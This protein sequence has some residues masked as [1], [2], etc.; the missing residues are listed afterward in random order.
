MI[1]REFLRNC[2]LLTAGTALSSLNLRAGTAMPD[3][4]QDAA[5]A[6]AEKL[7]LKLPIR[8]L[9]AKVSRTLKVAIVGAGN[10]GRVYA[11]YAQSYPA[12]MKV[13]AVSDINPERLEAMSDTHG[14]VE[15]RR[16]GDFHEILSAGKIADAMI[17]ALPDDLHYECCM[18][19]LD[20]GYDVL[21]EKP[22]AQTALQCKAIDSKTR[23][24][25]RVVGTCH[26]LRYAPY[27]IAMKETM[28]S[29]MIGDV[30]SVQHMEPIQYAH[31]AHSYVRGN[32]RDSKA[33]TPI[34]LAK[35]CHDLDIIKWM[36][37]KKCV[38]ISADGSLTHFKAENAPAGAP[39]RCTDGC[40]H[41]ATCP[42]SALDIYVRRKAHLGVFDLKNPRDEEE[43]LRKMRDSWYSRCVYHC[44]NDQPDHY[45]TEMLFEDGVTASFSMEA[46]APEG[47]RRTR[48]M[49]T[50]GYIEGDM[51]KFVVTDFRSSR[52]KVW[53]VRVDEIPEYKGSGHGGGDYALLRDF[54]EA[55][56]AQDVSK[57]SSNI[58]A[59]IESHL[60]G[61]AAER[62]RLQGKKVK[63]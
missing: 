48:I 23:K 39:L 20:L 13:V 16:F 7:D 37:E 3:M 27:F 35:S 55:V 18:K 24:T 32:W 29:G 63:L 25:G 56:D 61:F 11:R 62:S 26:V 17:I 22:I 34:I 49:G 14:V 46:F 12:A 28:R 59:S 4:L 9:E 40:P 44:D 42:Y 8:P 5:L 51:S 47:G 54:L 45:V 36:L 38:S 57:L 30:V 43:I 53:D 1:R 31:M 21:V 6:D 58:S 2:G 33:T 19:A 15:S 10:R 41:E 52:R 60:M 50:K